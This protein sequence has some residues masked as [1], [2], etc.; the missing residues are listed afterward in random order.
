LRG[1]LPPADRAALEERLIDPQLG[2]GPRARLLFA[3][4]HVAD[5]TGD[6]GR[7]VDCL[8]EANALSQEM[9]RRQKRE[10]NPADHKRFVDNLIASFDADLYK[11]LAV[12]GS[13]SR[14]PVF[15]FG[16]PR[17]G[18]TLIEQVLASHSC[19]HGAGELRLV[20][21]SFEAIPSALGRSEGPLLCLPHLEPAI[22]RRLAEQHLARLAALD[23]DR[24]ERIVDKMPDNYMYLGLVAAMFPR[25]V[26]IHC[27][28]DLRDVA[29]SCWMTDFRSIRWA[30]DPEHIAGRFQQYRRLMD[31]WQTVLE[32]SIH[33]VDYE[34]TVADLDGVARKLLAACG[35]DWE[36]ACAEFHRTPRPIRT[37]SVTQVRQP[38]YKQSAGRWRNYAIPLADLFVGLP[39]D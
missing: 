36:P 2:D 29:L 15:V 22:I 20:R 3:L 30:N 4:A 18:T 34:E 10:Y 37:A 19:V 38:I 25:A 7:A 32:G 39:T 13:D 9:A 5:A 33:E 14:R 23:G 17:S 24:A 35:F 28:R 27:R 21:Q 11:R 8:R 31:H 16:L 1:K 12:G 26:L 6:S